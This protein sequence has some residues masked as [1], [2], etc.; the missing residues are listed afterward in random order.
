[1]F[2]LNVCQFGD[3]ELLFTHQ[4]DRFAFIGCGTGSSHIR[5]LH[6]PSHK[7]AITTKKTVC[8][9]SVYNKGDI[10]LCSTCVSIPVILISIY[11]GFLYQYIGTLRYM[12]Y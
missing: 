2:K 3:N 10:G 5:A 4:F 1:M 9:T 8:L 7:C 6:C 12:T 11:R